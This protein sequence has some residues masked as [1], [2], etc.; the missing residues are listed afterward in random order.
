MEG[1]TLS[2]G[3]FGDHFALVGV[4]GFAGE[5]EFHAD[6]FAGPAIVEGVEELFQRMG[7]EAMTVIQDDQMD[8]I[9]AGQGRGKA[10]FRGG[11]GQGEGDEAT[12]FVKS[13]PT[14]QA[15][16][17]DDL[18][19]LGGIRADL[20][21]AGVI[22]EL[23]FD[24]VGDDAAQNLEAFIDDGLQRDGLA[25]DG[26]ALGKGAYFMEKFTGPVAGFKNLLKRFMGGVAFVDVH[27]NQF[28]AAE[29][30][31]DDVIEFMG[32]AAGKLV[33]GVELLFEQ[34]L[35]VIAGIG[36]SGRW[37]GMGKRVDFGGEIR[38]RSGGGVGVAWFHFDVTG[39]SV[40]IYEGRGDNFF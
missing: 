31:G 1:E 3:A 4:D 19:D 37:P 6:F 28:G 2:G 26:R 29:N 33:E 38:G 11:T 5:E 14:V 23:E 15:E 20:G 36:E 39:N 17:D 10:F 22:A 12:P 7:F 27:G 21:A 30:A 18:L 9:P 25:I 16:V 8:V 32:D 13:L 24:L 34:E 40:G 35:G